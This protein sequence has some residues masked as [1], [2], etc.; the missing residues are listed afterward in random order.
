MKGKKPAV[1]KAVALSYNPES[2]AQ[3]KVTATGKGLVAEKIIETAAAS[4]VPIQEDAS[5][6]HLLSQLEINESIPEELY[7]AVA[8][9]FA[10]VY[11]LDRSLKK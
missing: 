8:E 6:V 9:I 3:P 10:F 5:L 7:A 4:N 1:K 11:R 2:D